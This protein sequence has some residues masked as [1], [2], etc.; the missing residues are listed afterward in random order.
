MNVHPV[1]H[2]H[3]ISG[4]I[5]IG[6]K[7]HTATGKA[8]RGNRSGSAT[9]QKAVA[10][11]QLGLAYEAGDD[12]DFEVIRLPVEH[13]NAPKVFPVPSAWWETPAVTS[14]SLSPQ[15]ED[16][17]SARQFVR[18][19]LTCWGFPDLSDDAEMIIGELVVNAVRHG[20]S[21]AS[22]TTA[23]TGR[24]ENALRLCMLRRQH[25][26]MMAVVDPSNEAPQP[27]QS[28]WT[29]ESGRGLQIVGALSHVWGWSP[30]EG[31]GKAVWAVLKSLRAAFRGAEPAPP[32]TCTAASPEHEPSAAT[33]ATYLPTCVRHRPHGW[34]IAGAIRL[35]MGHRSPRGR[36]GAQHPGAPAPRERGPLTSRRV[37]RP[38][39]GRIPPGRSAPAWPIR[40]TG[41]RRSRSG[42]PC[43]GPERSARPAGRTAWLRRNSSAR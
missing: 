1:L 26:I 43:P 25:E 42:C 2:L 4:T 34:P 13:A 39:T 23:R 36:A 35:P 41:R 33:N 10:L 20:L 7:P 14:R 5:P 19:M 6:H 38:S 28:D 9:R 37:R 3:N 29:G 11:A 18:E 27:R 31:N 16:I 8:S 17:R 30:L 21:T 40:V 15:P 24:A 12:D 22:R 32:P